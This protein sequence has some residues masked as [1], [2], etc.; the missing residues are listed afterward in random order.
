MKKKSCK[1]KFEFRFST[2]RWTAFA[3]C[4]FALCCSMFFLTDID[5]EIRKSAVHYQQEKN[6]A[7]ALENDLVVH[8]LDVGQGDC[9]ILSLPDGKKGI[10]DAGD[11]IENSKQHIL[12]Y[13]K[14]NVFKNE[15]LVFDFAILTHSDADHIGG[16]EMVFENFVV[17][18]IYRPA[19]FFNKTENANLAEQ[20]L[21][22]KETERANFLGLFPNCDVPS[23]NAT[24][25][26][27][28]VYFRVLN[29][30]YL[31]TN[32]ENEQSEVV[33]SFAGLKIE[34]ETF[35]YCLQ[36]YSPTKNTYT[37]LNNFS[38]VLILSYNG[39][40][41]CLTG[42]VESDAENDILAV[43]DLPQVDALKLAHHGSKNSSSQAFLNA[44]NPTYIFISVGADNCYG[45]P[46]NEVLKRLNFDCVKNNIFRTDL[47]GDMLF[48]V[49]NADDKADVCIGICKLDGVFSVLKWWHIF[50]V[51][52]I[53][54]FFVCFFV[55]EKILVKN[56]DKP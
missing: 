45:H 25:C 53:I 24:T 23:L 34:N 2:L 11:N 46:D 41:I 48:S 29:A 42:D 9:I 39:R 27:T 35:G 16:M 40:S 22:N 32:M 36:F 19:I 55:K 50:I 10:I 7:K 28:G 51:L 3:V 14:Q 12:N 31:E 44:L 13:A 1:T 56:L 38:P 4:F 20:T 6:F 52:A 18:K 30:I 33:F 43:E 37:N 17:N 54:L 15:E 49:K 26:N 47:N 21:T 8:F 5:E